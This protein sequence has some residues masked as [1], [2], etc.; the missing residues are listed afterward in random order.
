MIKFFILRNIVSEHPLFNKNY[1]QY[2]NLSDCYRLFNDR[3]ITESIN[4][5]PIGFPGF[6]IYIPNRSVNLDRQKPLFIVSQWSSQTVNSVRVQ[7][8]SLVDHRTVHSAAESGA[9]RMRVYPSITLTSVKRKG[10]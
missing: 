6:Y 10:I 3:P 8:V 9:K 2:I 1:L 7:Y 4:F 5:I